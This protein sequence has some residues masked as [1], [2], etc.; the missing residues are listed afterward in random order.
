MRVASR[1]LLLLFM[2]NASVYARGVLAGTAVQ[3]QADMLYIVGGI[4]YNLTTN[5][6]TFLVDQIV[7]LE[8]SWQDA[9][10]VEVSSGETDR[11]L[12]FLLTN[13]GNGND[14]FILDYEHNTSNSFSPPPSSVR[15]YQDSDGNGIF[16]IATDVLVTDINL[17]ADANVT[18]F[19]V[20][21]IP[22]A[23]YTSSD[24]S[25]DGIKAESTSS[26]SVGADNQDGVDVVVRNA[27]DV[28]VGVYV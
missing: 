22:D 25:H 18:L 16:D 14:N 23:N 28:A 21:D 13:L 11:V 27:I 3:N 17:S 26:A 15:I 9:A 8:I 24:L 12:T 10:P 7:D 2:L 20:S 1:V 4:E 6:D 5:M 19:I